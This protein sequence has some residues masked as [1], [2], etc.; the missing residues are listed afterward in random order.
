MP[1]DSGVPKKSA[2]KFYSEEDIAAT[3]FG[4]YVIQVG[5]ELFKSPNGKMAF[6]K[7]RAEM[8]YDDILG[9]LMVMK[10][11]GS[12]AEQKDAEKCLLRLRIF[13]L[14]FH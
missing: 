13:P 5:D 11:E 14:R 6:S 1:S 10:K 8:F 9:G 3:E 12:E 4:T 7:D 2:Y